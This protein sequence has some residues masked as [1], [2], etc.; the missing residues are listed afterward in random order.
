[1]SSTGHR[2][3]RP[4]QNPDG[5]ERHVHDVQRATGVLAPRRP[6]SLVQSGSWRA[7]ARALLLRHESRR[8]T[9]RTP[10]PGPDRDD[11][12]VAP[13]R[14]RRPPRDGI[15]FSYFLPPRGAG[16]QERSSTI[17]KWWEAFGEANAAA[18]D[19]NGWSYFRREGYDAF[20]AGFGDSWP[21][22]NGAVGMTYEQASSG[23]G[24]IR[25]SD[26]TILT[27]RDAASH[28]YTAS[29]ATL[30]ASARRARERVRDYLA[31]RQ[32]AITDAERGPMRAIVIESVAGPGRSLARPAPRNL[33]R[34]SGGRECQARTR[35]VLPA[36]GPSRFAPLVRRRLHSRVLLA[37]RFSTDSHSTRHSSR[38]AREPETDRG[39]FYT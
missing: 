2:A 34:F 36:P 6:R 15:E 1:M 11:A 7:R 20:F 31:F 14:R 33:S 3:D 39:R 32:T 13:T 16:E 30:M 28:H 29:W 37:V 10:R 18:F 27:L 24:A 12:S 23:G 9:S 22:F 4:L 5:H 38:G 35:G 21:V 19:A 26:G 25:R 17:T 8:F